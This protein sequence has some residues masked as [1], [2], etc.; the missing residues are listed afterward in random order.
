MGYLYEAMPNKEVNTLQ[1]FVSVTD[2]KQ[3]RSIGYYGKKA[4]MKLR[5]R[6]VIS[7]DDIQRM[8]YFFSPARKLQ[9]KD[10]NTWRNGIDAN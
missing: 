10:S 4:L 8:N 9:E 1:Y 3:S 2:A 7:E 6:K 5:S